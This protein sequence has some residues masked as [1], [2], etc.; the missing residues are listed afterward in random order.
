MFAGPNGSGKS[1]LYEQLRK[2]GRINTEIYISADR[3]DKLSWAGKEIPEIFHK[4]AEKYLN[5][6]K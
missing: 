5:L 6:R 2:S 1:T 4:A 3:K